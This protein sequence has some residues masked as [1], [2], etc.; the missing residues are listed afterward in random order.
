MRKLLLSVWVVAMLALTLSCAKKSDQPRATVA[1]KDGTIYSGTVVST[2]PAEITVAGDDHQTRTFAV[3]DVRSIEYADQTPPPPAEQAQGQAPGQAPAGEP[4]GA[5]PP[6]EYRQSPRERAPESPSF[7]LPVGTRLS[8]RTNETIDS[9]TAVSGQTFA[10]Q[11]AQ[12]VMD[13]NGGVA[14]PRG[15]NAQI[16]IRDVSR[17]GTVTGTNE[18]ALDLEWVSVDGRRYQIDTAD[19]SQRGNAGLG[20]NKRTG[21]FVGGGAALG[22]V[23]GAIAGGGKGAAIGA[24]SGAGAG[25]ATQVLTRGKAIRVPAETLLTFRLDKA[26]RVT[27]AR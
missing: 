24:I 13:A 5:P 21:A 17:S 9:R 23:I 14:I 22:A 10:G 20:K 2:T 11:V 26:L 4:A 16:V 6:P 25:A 27:P 3:K 8:V 7:L 12:D 15:S 19:I 1:L 18:L